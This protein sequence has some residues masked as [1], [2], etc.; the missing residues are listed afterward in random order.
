MILKW[1]DD[2]CG[3][4]IHWI[5]KEN[6]VT[7]IVVEDATYSGKSGGDEV[8]PNNIYQISFITGTVP[9]GYEN[10]NFRLYLAALCSFAEASFLGQFSNFDLLL[11]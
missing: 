2:I 5:Q 10:K 6:G 11:T 9:Y 8:Q 1:H 4:S 7:R 3:A